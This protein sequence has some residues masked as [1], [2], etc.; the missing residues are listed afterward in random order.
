MMNIPGVGP[1]TIAK[2]YKK[3]KIK[4]I[5]ELEK[6]L[7]EKR[8]RRLKGFGE[9]SEEK[10]LAG[11]KQYKRH[12]ERFPLG[13]VAPQAE[14]IVNQ[15]KESGF[16]EQ[17]SVAG[18]IRRMKETIGDIDILV[19]SN[20]PQKVMDVF[21]N[22]PE[23][24]EVM[25]KGRTKSM[26]LLKTGIQADVRV[27]A[28]ESFGAALYYFTGS[29]AHNIH[30]RKL[31]LE[32]GLTINEYGVFRVTG[33]K[34][35]KRVAGRTEEEVFAAIGLPYIE[36]ELREDL[37]EIEAGLRQT[38]S[39]PN[40]LPKL[41]ELKDIKGDLHIHSNWADGDNSIEE[42]MEEAKK[43]GYQYIAITDHTPTVGITGGL[44]PKEILKQIEYIKKLNKKLKDF[45][46]LAGIECDIKADGSL[47]TPDEILEKLDVVIA[48]VH[49]SFRQNEEKMTSRIIKAMQNKNVD[50]IGHPTGRVINYR[51]AYAVNLDRLFEVAKNTGTIFE[52]NAFWNRLD[53]NDVNCRKAKD[54]GIKLE[55]GTDAHHVLALD[56]M[57]YGVATARR[58]WIEKKNVINTLPY[59]QLIKFFKK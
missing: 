46:V 15:L 19:T 25:A 40:G 43:R 13:I 57:K 7:K 21:V 26:V 18:S 2:L 24:K 23:V 55:I 37:G 52:V 11:I 31:A 14:N 53:L 10:I 30:A 50:I 28:P 49:T 54:R 45:V 12:A 33:K 42:I 32:K 58:G 29:K 4:N 44:K 35:G 22:L 6:F 17:I 20:K 41:V 39:K 48:S 59:E 36:P 56:M 34:K 27:V 9:K 38:Q 51:D 8:L 16:V 3:F 1:K 5:D 47:D